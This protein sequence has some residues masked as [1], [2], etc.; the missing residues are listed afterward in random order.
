M[1]R[2]LAEWAKARG[3]ALYSWD[4]SINVSHDSAAPAAIEKRFQELDLKALLVI[5]PSPF[6]N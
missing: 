1:N 3:M 2:W 4:L 5:F 6:K